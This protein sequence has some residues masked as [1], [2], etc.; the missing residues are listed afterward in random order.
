VLLSSGNY[1]EDFSTFDS[2]FSKST[3]HR[4]KVIF[5]SR[6]G[7]I[8]EFDGITVFGTRIFEMNMRVGKES[9]FEDKREVD[10]YRNT[11]NLR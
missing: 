6:G 1:T 5:L 11:E 8:S 2:T 3:G 4:W 10:V 9:G 7:R